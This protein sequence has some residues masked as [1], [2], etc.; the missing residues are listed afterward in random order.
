MIYNENN[1]ILAYTF[2]SLV[3]M[4]HETQNSRIIKATP[5]KIYQA[6]TDPD[7]LEYWQVPGSM[8][9]KVHSYDLREGGGYTMS[10]FYPDDELKMTGKTSGKEDKFTARFVTLDPPN[11]I[12]EAVLFQSTDPRFSG[13]MIIEISLQ[14]VPEGTNV[15]FSFKD[16]PDGI[17]PEDNEAGTI[18]SLEKLARYVE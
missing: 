17:K 8:T 11:K 16:I 7:A 14:P 3:T 13:E 18:S 12:V 1:V 5:D 9:A 4:K 2:L 10:L 6:I 15:T